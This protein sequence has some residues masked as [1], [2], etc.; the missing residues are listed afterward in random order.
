[1]EENKENNELVVLIDDD[2][3]E[4][5]FIVVDVIPVNDNSYA[6]LMPHIKKE[7]SNGEVDADELDAFIFRVSEKNGE[8]ILEEVD[9]EDE[10]NLVA[11]VWENTLNELEDDIDSDA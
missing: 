5:T 2:G 3:E 10:W 9:E 11:E 7:N 8:Q 1:M 6:I 4:H